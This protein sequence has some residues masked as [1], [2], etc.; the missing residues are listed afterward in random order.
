[1]IPARRAFH[2]RASPRLRQDVDDELRFHLEER[3]EEFVERGMTRE[4][5]ER[6]VRRRFGDVDAYGRETQHIDERLMRDRNRLD[7]MDALRREGR[8][9]VRSL[10]R[11]PAFSIIALVTLAL[12]IGATTAL[13]TILEAVVLRPLPYAGAERLVS[14][15]HP[16]EVPGSGASRWGL[17]EAGYFYFRAQS[18]TLQELGVYTTGFTS[19]LGERDAER[20]RSAGV[21]HTLLTVLGAR[22][23]AGRLITAEDDRPGAAPV[24]MLGWDFWQRRWGGDPAVLGSTIQTSGGPAEVVGVL[25]PGFDLPQPG[26]GGS[27]DL[28]GF[29]VDVWSPLQLSDTARAVNSHYLAGIGRLRDGV[30][31]EMAERDL[32]TLTARLP[33]LFPSAYSQSFMDEYKFRAGAAPLRDEVLG[34]T[35]VRTLWVLFAAT[36]LVLLIAGANVAN[37][38]LV[39]MEARR[40][41]AAIRDALGADRRHLAIHYLSESLLLSLAAGALGLL[42]AWALVKAVLVVAPSDLPRLDEVQ[43]RWTVIAFAAAVSVATGLLFGT[44]P[45][46]RPRV[47]DTQTLR[48]GSRGLSA[49]PRQRAARN[50]LVVAQVALALVLLVAAG[51]M[52]RSVAH[53][54][55][56]DPGLRA[57]GVLTFTLA[58]P[59]ARYRGDTAVALFHRRVQ[60]RLAA[61]PGVTGVGVGAGL[62][63]RD[64]GSHCAVVFAEGQRPGDGAEPPCVPVPKVT[65]GYLEALGIQVRGRTHTW[66]DLDAGTG[67]AVVTQ[68]LADRLWPGED[69]IGKGINSNGG[70]ESGY[71]R[72]V[73]VVP[74]LRAKGLD[75]PPTEMVFYPALHV[76][77][78]WVASWLVAPSYVVR[79]SLADP[80][81]LVAAVRRTVA[82]VDP[83]VP[84]ANVA[85]MEQVLDRSMARTSFIMLLLGLAS[86]MALLLSAVGIYGVISYIVGQRRSEIGVRIALGA[87]VGEVARMVVLQSVALAL[88]GVALGLVA[89]VGATRV[90]QSLLFGVSPTDPP[91]LGVV[92]AVLLLL[93]AVASFA[94]A[95]RAAS[96]DPVVALR[97]Q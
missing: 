22:P 78:S 79:T 88:A 33:E 25:P 53:L 17:S 24:V 77:R 30:T 11:T 12:G 18:R 96:V 83:Q 42:L 31:A 40:R 48:E 52:G 14:V 80:V 29:R 32:Q 20:A 3:I 46:L 6:E 82:E 65:P 72:V 76:P 50:A 68:A 57:D 64:L 27:G 44:F 91:V 37:L 94:P 26:I 90:L 7:M 89:A 66:G 95:R 85:T 2:L 81:S 67:A 84:M 59:D 38:F 49:S 35:I 13:Y 92:A 63:L 60:E 8:H 41:E 93:A 21:T 19:V 1:M 34:A 58:L 73:G 87:R 55:Q 71:Y 5:A 36:G 54:R 75:Q 9:A 10:L 4:D 86:A 16:A 15:R 61:L 47:A 70:D 51:L 62:P 97:G 39:R 28:S 56:V 74:E 23:E 43:L 69:P 45:L